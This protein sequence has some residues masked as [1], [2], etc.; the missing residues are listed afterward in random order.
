M[1]ANK[2]DKV[3]MDRFYDAFYGQFRTPMRK[4]MS[5]DLME[6]AVGFMKDSE[7]V[8]TGVSENDV[9]QLGLIDCLAIQYQLT[10][11][12]KPFVY[13]REYTAALQQERDR[14]GADDA[15]AVLGF[16]MPILKYKGY[17]RSTLLKAWRTVLSM[18]FANSPIQMKVRTIWP[19]L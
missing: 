3:L 13:R 8:K 17:V 6:A 9:M 2:D 19:L 11:F 15:V 18:I 7:V 14:T 12:H 5:D 1:A 10:H 4:Y 16:P